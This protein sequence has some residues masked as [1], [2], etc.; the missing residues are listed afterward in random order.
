MDFL[1]EENIKANYRNKPSKVV[2]NL[3]KKLKDS[4]IIITKADKETKLVAVT[5]S[6]YYDG[7]YKLL[8]DR[9][10]FQKY[11]PPPRGRG[12]PSTKN[13]FEIAG[14]LVKNF[15]DSVP[16]LTTV[17]KCPLSTR[18]PFLYG[19][20]KTHKNKT[21]MPFRPVLSATGCYNFS[22]AKFICKVIS[23]F[24]Y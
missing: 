4:S 22:L 5:K 20:A 14:E 8:G 23:P 6:D 18:Q 10:K 1:K 9:T 19:L 21:P 12:R 2:Q 15:V 17:V 13:A 3:I 7:L 11:V 24:C 16:G